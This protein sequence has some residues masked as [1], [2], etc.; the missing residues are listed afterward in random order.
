MALVAHDALLGTSAPVHRPRVAHRTRTG[1]GCNPLAVLPPEAVCH[2]LSWLDFE[3]ARAFAQTCRAAHVIAWDHLRRRHTRLCVRNCDATAAGALAWCATESLCIETPLCSVAALGGCSSHVLRRL[4]LARC[5][6]QPGT[7]A[8]LHGLGA[9]ERLEVLDCT[10]HGR[11]CPAAPMPQGLRAIAV[12]MLDCTDAALLDVLCVALAYTAPRLA[13]AMIAVESWQTAAPLL[14]ALEA[15]AAMCPPQPLEALDVALVLCTPHLHAPTVTPSGALPGLRHLVFRLH[16]LH[17]LQ[18]LHVLYEYLLRACTQGAHSLRELD[19]GGSFLMP[20]AYLGSLLAQPR[21]LEA[22]A[23]D[24]QVLAGVH[25]HAALC[26]MHGLRD[27]NISG[28]TYSTPP[29]LQAMPLLE[30]LCVSASCI[31]GAWLAQVRAAGQLPRLREL[32]ARMCVGFG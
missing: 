8:R 31:N 26:G 27:L 24:G 3:D 16:A 17:A 9:L 4:C 1:R 19:V 30:R 20:D 5:V 21:A 22:L 25:A 32:D 7:L 2:A 15:R 11:T 28:T 10:L 29:F 12:R 14:H 23:I 13:E 6:L 18:P